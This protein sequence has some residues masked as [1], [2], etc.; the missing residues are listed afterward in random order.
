MLDGLVPGDRLRRRE[1]HARFGGRE[2]GGISPSRKVPIVMFFTDPVTG[3]RH[4]YYDGLDEAGLYNYVGEGQHGDQRLVQGNK[5]ILNHAKDGRSLEG[6]LANGPVV[7]YL[8]EFDLVDHHFTEAHESGDP[9]TI[10][11][12]VVFRL[13]PR[14]EIFV[15]LP[16]VPV[17][18]QP[19]AR[20]DLVW[21]ERRNT[22]V[23]FVAPDREPYRVER[24]EAAL[25]HQYRDHL[26]SQGH[27]VKRLKVIPPGESAPLYSDLWDETTEDLIEA[28]GSVTREQVRMA[29]GQL[30]D[31]QRFIGARTRTLLV[32]SRPR[33]DLLDYLES[34]GTRVVYPEADEWHTLPS[35][36][37]ATPHDRG[38][39]RHDGSLDPLG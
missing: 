12:V 31:Y 26:V 13:R 34:A 9:S 38:T 19:T 11:Q 16:R 32:P 1:V 2:Q 10:R 33:E 36:A 30:L 5:A 23:A 6:F 24:R 15:N 18:K 22:E 8:G 27:N 4:G 25:V 20:V 7:T 29:V 37:A 21:V 14:G 39:S 35:Q 3:H 17:T 28:K